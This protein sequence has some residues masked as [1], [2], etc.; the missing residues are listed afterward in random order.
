MKIFTVD[1]E[2]RRVY[3][4]TFEAYNLTAAETVIESLDDGELFDVIT[5]YP[6]EII[7]DEIVSTDN[8]KESKYR[9]EE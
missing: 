4:V 1:I 5:D 3:Q 8:I 6:A 2:V 7:C 9:D